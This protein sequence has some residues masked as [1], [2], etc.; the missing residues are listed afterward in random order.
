MLKEIHEQPRALE[1]AMRGRLLVTEGTARLGGLR[2]V[3]KRSGRY[4]EDHPG[5]MWDFVS[6][7]LG[8]GIYA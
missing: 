2:E 1:D 6:C 8:G 5:L 3:E 4:Q 7:E